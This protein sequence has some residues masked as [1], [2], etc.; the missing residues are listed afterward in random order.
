METGYLRR[1]SKRVIG[2]YSSLQNS[3]FKNKKDCNY[4]LNVQHESDNCGDFYSFFQKM[5]H[6]WHILSKC[7]LKNTF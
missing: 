4:S 3:N 2:K 5:S 1:V 7:L 6:F